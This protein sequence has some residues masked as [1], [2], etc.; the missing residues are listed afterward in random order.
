MLNSHGTIQGYNGQA[1]VAPKK[2][3]IVHDEAFGNGQDHD[4]I[5]PMVDGAKEN[6]RAI[7]RG[8]TAFLRK[9]SQQADSSYHSPMN[10]KKCDEGKLDAYIP[11]KWFRKREGKLSSHTY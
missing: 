6:M 2:Q 4:H 11:D 8:E 7:G 10:L 3:V 1:L 9:P 5:P